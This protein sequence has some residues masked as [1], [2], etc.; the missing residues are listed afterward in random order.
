MSSTK[1]DRSDFINFIVDTDKDPELLDEFMGKTNAEE[2]YTFFQTHEYKD[3]PAND[4]KDIIA[5]RKLMF[6]RH[7]PKKG[8]P[9]KGACVPGGKAY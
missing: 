7:I 8:Q 1:R 4:C 9:A 2:L 3:I 5:A 6:G